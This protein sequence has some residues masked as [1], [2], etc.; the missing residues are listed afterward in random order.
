MSKE[1]S[2]LRKKN[3]RDTHEKQKKTK[4]KSLL[5]N[6]RSF[7]KR[8]KWKPLMRDARHGKKW[9]RKKSENR[10]QKEHIE[11]IFKSTLS[12]EI[13]ENMKTLWPF[14]FRMMLFFLTNS[15]IRCKVL[16]L[17]LQGPHISIHFPSTLHSFTLHNF[18]F[19]HRAFALFFQLL[20]HCVC[21]DSSRVNQF[22]ITESS[23]STSCTTQSR[24]KL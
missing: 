15:L 6:A 3:T 9:R 10:P 21:T 2:R 22:R 8:Q 18:H 13:T 17:L 11:S 1:T 24:P 12:V 14:L 23:F 7:V 16:V 5:F 19:A 4:R 20:L